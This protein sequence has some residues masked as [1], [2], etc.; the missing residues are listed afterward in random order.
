M[1]KQLLGLVALLTMPLAASVCRIDSC[2]AEVTGKS[3]LVS[4]QPFLSHSPELVSGFRY[5]RPHA[6]EDG[7]RGASQVVIFGNKSLNT[8][9][10]TRYFM[11][12]GKLE[13]PVSG[14]IAD[15]SGN[16]NDL[17][18]LAENFNIFTKNDASFLSA[19][20]M[21]P[22]QSMMGVGFYYRQSFYRDTEKNRGFWGSV[23]FA[24]VRVKNF[25]KFCERVVNDGGGV[26]TTLNPNAVANMME[27]V[28]QP[29]W[30]FGK[31]SPVPLT[32]TGLADMEIKIGYE[33]LDFE[34]VHLESY[35]GVLV[36]TGNTPDGKYL[37]EPIVGQGH[38]PGIIWGSSMGVQIWCNE[39]HN[40]T[41]RAEYAFHSQY[42][43][44]HTQCRSF[45]L[46][47]KPWSRY[48]PVYRNKEDAAFAQSITTSNPALA[49]TYSTPGINVFTQ[50]L[51]V[52]P[53]FSFNMLTAIVFSDC[54]FQAELG[55]NFWARQS[56]CVKLACPWQQ[57][58]AIKDFSGE[59]QTN[60]VRDITNNPLLNNSGLK[61]PFDEF[62]KNTILEEQLDLVSAAQPAGISNT[63]YGALTYRWDDRCFPLLINA[64][65]SYEMSNSNNSIISRWAAWGKFGVSF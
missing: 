31:I 17:F 40:R 45:D 37:W 58:V 23:S 33:W 61:Q 25:L 57:V 18:L 19:I 12:F 60:P 27:A 15:F 62:D 2:D 34:P 20:S 10:L 39:Y 56:E 32:K 24:A 52:T 42:L 50:P 47:N 3:Y 53:R 14:A 30:H 59:G 41:L 55:Y 1:K 16:N 4:R 22:E 13:L 63:V 65:A 26:D 38:H 7:A 29:A 8:D 48:M 46:K 49:G 43:F 11:P 35:A 28:N 44:Q 21:A 9:D 54:G 51:E 64:G 36:P 6:K 5:D